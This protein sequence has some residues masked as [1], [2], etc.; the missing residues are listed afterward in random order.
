MNSFLDWLRKI[1]KPSPP[2]PPVLPP[3]EP[4]PASIINDLFVAHNKERVKAGVN[5]L[6]LNN[7]LIAAA[8]K[9]AQWMSDNELLSHR[10]AYGSNSAD[11]IYKEGYQARTTGENIAKGYDSTI[12]V[13]QGWMSSQG[14]RNNILSSDFK[15][16]GFAKAGQYW[17]AVFAAP[18]N[19][20]NDVLT[21]NESGTLF[22]N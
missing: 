15:Q 17:C 21:I 19:N 5:I 20:K 4:L 14:H 10:G 6:T 22:K 9:H 16:C 7:H 1:I 11:R 12:A 3:T 18:I 2:T 8:E 13:M